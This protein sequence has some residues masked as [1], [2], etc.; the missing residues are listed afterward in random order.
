[1]EL[2]QGRA[3]RGP[4]GKEAEAGAPNG[5]AMG[6]RREQELRHHH[7]SIFGLPMLSPESRAVRA[8]DTAMSALDLTY[9]GAI[10]ALCLAGCSMA[11]RL[12]CRVLP[13]AHYAPCDGCCRC[14][15]VAK[16]H[17][18]ACAAAYIVPLSLAFDNMEGAHFT[19]FNGVNVAGSESGRGVTFCSYEQQPL[20]ARSKP[21]PPPSFF[22][23]TPCPPSRR[24]PG[25]HRHGLPHRLHRGAR[26][27]ARAGDGGGRP[28]AAIRAARRGSTL[29]LPEHAAPPAFPAT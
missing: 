20:A 3:E 19:W 4:S 6:Y 24:L 9:T 11:V 21:P 10:L 18:A 23:P 1:M 29:H 13:T 14:Q 8:W 22:S 27:E 2:E 17:T 26:R 25:G 5:S 15:L 28:A 16:N 12:R 7:R